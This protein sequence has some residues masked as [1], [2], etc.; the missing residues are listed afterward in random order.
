MMADTAEEFKVNWYRVPV[1][2]Q[3]L[4]ALT[5]RSD[6]KGLLQTVAYLGLLVL[7]GAAAL[8]A[9]KRLPLGVFIAVL[10]VHG[11]FF[12]FT[13]NAFHELCHGTVFRSRFL[14]AF[15]LR[16]ISFVSWNN[17]ALFRASHN[18]HHWHTLHP[19]H[20][21]EVVLRLHFSLKTFLIAAVADPLMLYEVI[22]QNVRFSL[23]ILK[24]GWETTIFPASDPVLRRQ[25]FRFARILLL[26]HAIIVTVSIVSGLWPV[27]L[28]ITGARFYGGWLFYLCNNTQHVGLRDN[29]PDFRL[30]CRT[31]EL[32]PFIRFLYWQMNYH[33]E[34]H[35]YAA[36][37]CY[38]LRKLHR[39][40]AHEM[41]HITHGLIPAWREIS[42]IIRRQKIEP[43]YQHT[44]ELPTHPATAVGQPAA[45]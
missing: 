8:Y 32:N 28:L 39:A 44:H 16:I 12:G 5:Q 20:D 7:T 22:K 18:R 42:G 14:N 4:R 37:P 23:G 34:H 41:P 35:M 43:G 24:P 15:F 1:E 10:F 29:V 27:A 9:W 2:K 31:I 13:V 26:G 3:T 40:I 19:P 21:L 6:W 36:V 11:T 33:T 17:Y 38:N 25:L 45:G 30:C